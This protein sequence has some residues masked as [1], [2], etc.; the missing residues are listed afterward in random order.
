MVA[1]L[2]KP[3]H[4]DYLASKIGCW[5]S[6]H[7]DDLAGQKIDVTDTFIRMLCPSKLQLESMVFI[8]RN[9]YCN[10]YLSPALKWWCRSTSTFCKF[11]IFKCSN[12][13]SKLEDSKVRPVK[14]RKSRF[15]ATFL[16]N[17][18]CTVKQFQIKIQI[19]VIRHFD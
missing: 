19:N 3:A 8:P 7:D 5:W 1:C 15:S 11:T 12:I 2:R 13:Q 17:A 4:S 14:N 18:H 6:L 10:T 16:K 9:F